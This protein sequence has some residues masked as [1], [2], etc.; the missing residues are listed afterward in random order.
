MKDI[1][2]F[3]DLHANGRALKDIIPLL[4][5]V[6]LSI[7]CGDIIG[8]GKDIDSCIDF[9]LNNIDLVVI[10]NHE[11][12]AV[13]DEDLSNQDP[14]VQKS[15]LYNRRKLTSKQKDLLVS[16]PT[17]IWYE[18]L[19]VTHSINDEYLK[20]EADFDKLFKKMRE[21]TS[22]A[23]FGHTHEQVLISRNKKTIINPGSITKGRRGLQRGYLLMNAAKLIFVRLESI[24]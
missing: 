23:F 10:G 4:D 11:R 9:I 6:D 24:L 13:S 2:V 16:L 22:Y 19:Y 8:Y 14:V 15:A 17:E 21:G 7:F 1:L 20:T 5:D 12:L 18:D 3:S